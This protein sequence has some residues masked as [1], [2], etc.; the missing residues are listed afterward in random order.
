MAEKKGFN[1]FSG[2][3]V[4]FFKEL[5]VNNNK[6]WFEEHRQDYET[7]VLKPARS[8]IE[9]MGQLL[10]SVSPGVHADARVNKSLFRINRDTRFSK[11]KSPYKT[12]LGIWF[13]E[14]DG[15]RME[16]SGYYFHLEPHKLMLAAGIQ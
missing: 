3:T 16:C 5:A 1:G 7:Y 4:E 11:D 10:S 2:R 6:V 8:F 12:H 9:G 14:G 13:W 15:P